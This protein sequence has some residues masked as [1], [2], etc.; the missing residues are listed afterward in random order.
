MNDELQKALAESIGKVVNAAEAGAS[1]LQAELPEVIR[2]LLFY[3]VVEYSFYGTVLLGIGVQLFFK[4]AAWF[5][6]LANEGD[7]DPAIM[8][9]GGGCVISGGM[10]WIGI[11]KFMFLLQILIAPKI[12][13]IEFAASLVRK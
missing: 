8:V 4:S 1:F 5:K 10:I 13:L 6:K 11:L 3:K 2:Q 7:G 12:Y 9:A